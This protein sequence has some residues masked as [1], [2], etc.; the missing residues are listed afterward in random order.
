MSSEDKN[1]EQINDENI[2][3]SPTETENPIEVSSSAF[4]AEINHFS[5]FC[6]MFF[7]SRDYFLAK[8]TRC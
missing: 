2:D 8:S 5:D 7:F 6:I 1:I 3:E 4:C